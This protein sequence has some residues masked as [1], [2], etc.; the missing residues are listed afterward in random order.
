[1]SVTGVVFVINQGLVTP[2]NLESIDLI[3]GQAA[4]LKFKRHEEEVL[5]INIY[6]PNNK[7]ENTQFW[8][9]LDDKRRSKR[10]R[11][12]DFLLG[13]FN[14]TEDPIDRAPAHLD[15]VNAISALRNMCQVLGL[16]DEWRHIYPNKRCFTY[17]AKHN[18]QQIKLR[19]NRIYC[20]DKAAKSAFDWKI[21]QMSVPTDHWMVAAKYAPREAPYMGKGRWTWQL[22]E[23][24]NKELMEKVKNR[25]I[26]LQHDIE[27]T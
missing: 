7:Q 22:T 4:A 23:I 17:Q 5:L 8:E 18:S 27:N 9:D 11:C 13:D 10:L 3:Q 1:M 16:K 14:V 21:K 15:D 19:I 20:S 26:E 25:G 12:P 24:K 6:T 2:T